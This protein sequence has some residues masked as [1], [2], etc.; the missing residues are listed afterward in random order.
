M[1]YPL[2]N[3]DILFDNNIIT[4]SGPDIKTKGLLIGRN[5]QNLRR[6]EDII[7]R[8]FKFDKIIVK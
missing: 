1:I 4:I 7:K 5:S 3:L 2:K 6:L 8:Y